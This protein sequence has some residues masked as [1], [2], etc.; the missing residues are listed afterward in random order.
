ML[1]LPSCFVQVP[2]VGHTSDSEIDSVI[3]VVKGGFRSVSLQEMENA[4]TG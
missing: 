1:S 4:D 3:M 2:F